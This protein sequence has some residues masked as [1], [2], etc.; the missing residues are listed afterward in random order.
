MGWCIVSS[1]NGAEK[2][3]RVRKENLRG[4]LADST[5][6]YRRDHLES[7]GGFNRIRDL[8]MVIIIA[9]PNLLV[10]RLSQTAKRG[11]AKYLI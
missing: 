9:G 5:A 10:K 4:Y 11:S 2:D 8:P 7:G 1:E 3:G 6:T